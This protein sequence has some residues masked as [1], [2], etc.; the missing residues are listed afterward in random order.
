M[1]ISNLKF[2]YEPW[3]PD[4][5]NVL[6]ISRL[7]I[8]EKGCHAILGPNG[9]GKT[10]LLKLAAGLLVP[11]SGVVET[12]ANAVMVHQHPYLLSGSV[13]SNVAYGLKIKK[14]PRDE[15]ERRVTAE[16]DRWGLQALKDRHSQKLSGGEKQRTAIARAMVLKPDLLLLD[17][18]TASVDP[19]NI[20]Q[21]ENLI[22]DIIQT[23]TTVVFSTHHVDFAYRTADSII[24]LENGKPVEHD[25]N[26]ISGKITGHDEYFNFYEAAGTTLYCPGRDGDFRRAVFSV[27]D[28]I[29]SRENIKSS[30]RNVME[31]VV[32]E[33]IEEG[34]TCMVELNA[35]FIFKARVSAASVNE[36]GLEKGQKIFAVLKSSAIRLY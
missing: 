23:G 35:G 30:A 24:K 31:S 32:A 2:S 26:M 34:K 19:E 10:T 33:I 27:N 17:E 5:G 7:D 15:I 11:E 18:P 13:F 28:V 29:L 12:N 8:P 3:N 36:L 6:D 21:M 22:S 1:R 4:N 20:S 16:L 14:I 25:E 9:C